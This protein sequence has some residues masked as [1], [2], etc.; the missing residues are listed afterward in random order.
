MRISIDHLDVD[1]IQKQHSPSLG[2]SRA[3]FKLRP[4]WPGVNR[5]LG[6]LTVASIRV[7]TLG[8]LKAMREARSAKRVVHAVRWAFPGSQSTARQ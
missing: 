3:S 8:A 6:C 2:W 7:C 1:P 5:A 4:A